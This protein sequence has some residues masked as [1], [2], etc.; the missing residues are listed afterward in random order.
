MRA[1]RRIAGLIALAGAGCLTAGLAVSANA[2]SQTENVY[3]V[4]NLTTWETLKCVAVPG[5]NPADKVQVIQFPCNIKLDSEQQWAVT[6]VGLD[7]Y[8][9]SS[10]IF[11][12]KKTGKCLTAAGGNGGPVWQYTCLAAHDNQIW[13]YDKAYRLHNHSSGD[14]LAVPG[15]PRE[16]VVKLIHWTCGDG[17]EQKWTLV[18][19]G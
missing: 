12:N 3:P 8:D 18:P 13:S 2:S 1:R 16:D 5:A 17:K 10:Y 14:C 4:I 6:D 9:N 15:G 7:D 11:K 19:P